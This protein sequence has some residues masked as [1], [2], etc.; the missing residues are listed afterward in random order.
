LEDHLEQLSFSRRVA[1]LG[2]FGQRQF[3]GTVFRF[4]S[5]RHSTAKGIVKAAVD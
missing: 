4:I 2:R 3:S 1:G 5:P